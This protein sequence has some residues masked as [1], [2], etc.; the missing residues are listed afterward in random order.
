MHKS[1]IAVDKQHQYDLESIP[2][3]QE[4]AS[5]GTEQMGPQPEP[6][7][8]HVALVGEA[9]WLGNERGVPLVLQDLLSSNDILCGM[10]KLTVTRRFGTA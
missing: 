6:V 9:Q 8:M 1:S 7:T 5:T 2:D 4:A 3:M 10:D